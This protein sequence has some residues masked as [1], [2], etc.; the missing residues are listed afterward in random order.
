MAALVFRSHFKKQPHWAKVKNEEAFDL[1]SLTDEQRAA[2]IGL[3]WPMRLYALTLSPDAEMPYEEMENGSAPPDAE[4]PMGAIP[5][6]FTDMKQRRRRS[7][8]SM[9]RKRALLNAASQDV[10]DGTFGRW[11]LDHFSPDLLA[12]LLDERRHTIITKISQY[13][14]EDEMVAFECGM[15]EEVEG[16][17]DRVDGLERATLDAIKARK[18]KPAPPDSASEV[19]HS[20]SQE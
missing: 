7:V 14:T 10:P 18:A 11:A 4:I 16:F 12:K 9:N 8:Y 1:N 17:D 13:I 3:S 20:P 6:P 19:E 2:G 15:Q 5:S